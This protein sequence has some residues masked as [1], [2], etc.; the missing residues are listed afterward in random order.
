LIPGS[1]DFAAQK[2]A[3]DERVTTALVAEYHSIFLVAAGLC[4]VAGA[5]AMLT[6]SA[7]LTAG[8]TTVSR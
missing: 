8:S 2:A 7:R 5:I 1:P 3:F 4:L 6:L